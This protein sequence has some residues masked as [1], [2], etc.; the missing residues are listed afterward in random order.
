[1]LSCG[2]HDI[3]AS[4][5]PKATPSAR[6]RPAGPCAAARSTR[7]CGRVTRSLHAA[8]QTL[9]LAAAA[10]RKRA[11]PG[12]A[13]SRAAGEERGQV[14]GHRLPRARQLSRAL[15]AHR[16]A[17]HAPAALRWAQSS[18]KIST[19]SQHH[20]SHM[21]SARPPDPVAIAELAGQSP[22]LAIP[23]E[24][25]CHAKTTPGRAQGAQTDAKG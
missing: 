2:S 23:C 22:N 5:K 13:A 24:A 1:M 21:M 12:A 8:A 18:A 6:Q 10:L 4:L 11:Q 3:R 20:H 9:T 7:L 19:H 17:A 14:V 15:L 25:V 16:R